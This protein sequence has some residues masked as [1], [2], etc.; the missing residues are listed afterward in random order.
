ME[1]NEKEVVVP[2]ISEEVHADV[3][4]VETGGVRVTKR[5]EGHDEILEQELRRGRVEVKRVKVNRVVQGPQPIQHRGSTVIVPVVSEVI[6]VEKQ[7]VVTEEIHITQIEERETVQQKVTV[8]EEQAEVERLDE[9]GEAIESIEPTREPL[10]LSARRPSSVID[11]AETTSSTSDSNSQGTVLSNRRSLI[12]D[13][14]ARDGG[15][16]K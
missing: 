3:K 5:V 12:K 8:N 4:P 11:R 13:K 10:I 15:G 16:P 2:V 6:H 9:H 7:W 14:R 1:Q